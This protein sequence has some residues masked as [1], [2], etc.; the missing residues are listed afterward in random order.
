MTIEHCG[1]IHHDEGPHMTN[2]TELDG[3]EESQKGV[4]NVS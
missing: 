1:V 3:R 4:L 2:T